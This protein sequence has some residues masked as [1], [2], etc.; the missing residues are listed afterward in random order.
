MVQRANDLTTNRPASAW[1]TL[2][3]SVVTN[4][5]NVDEKA[6]LD[7]AEAQSR[8]DRVGANRLPEAARQPVWL[9][10]LLQFH[11]ILIYVLLGSAVIT[12]LLGH[13]WDTVVILAVVI[14]NAIIGFIQE[15]KAEKA[16][17]AIRQMLAPHAAVLRGGERR[18]I[19]GEQLVPGD[20]VMLEAADKVP[21][22]L[23][24]L[25]AHRLQIQE[26]ILTGESVPVEKHTQPVASEAVLG[27]R[28]CMAFSGTLVTS[29][30]A[31]GVGI[32][33]GGSADIGRISSLLSGVGWLPPPPVQPVS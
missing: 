16:M 15:G 10:F 22:D 13:L 21:A 1:H 23:R 7:P 33:T 30:Q 4:Q 17:D 32:A 27:D 18:S 24:L 20:I 11:N 26:A 28:A 29:G 19:A 8:L 9:R 6:G 31:T 25:Q 12:G 3:A 2:P 5:L 14:A